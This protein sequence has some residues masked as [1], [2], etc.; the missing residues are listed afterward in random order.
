M[1]LLSTI[2]SNIKNKYNQMSI[3]SV[4]FEIQIIINT[5]IYNTY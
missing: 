1:N 5:L 4:S 2:N 3:T